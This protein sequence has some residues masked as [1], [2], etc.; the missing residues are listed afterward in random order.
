MVFTGC[1]AERRW[2]VDP[3]EETKEGQLATFVFTAKSDLST[4]GFRGGFNNRVSVR[5]PAKLSSRSWLA[6][7]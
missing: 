6:Q 3:K 2:F 5:T 1:G 4:V 7:V